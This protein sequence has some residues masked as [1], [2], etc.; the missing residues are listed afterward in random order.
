[1]N[2]SIWLSSSVFL[3]MAERR[4]WSDFLPEDHVS[5]QT[6]WS[7]SDMLSAWHPVALYEI[8]WELLLPVLAGLLPRG[9]VGGGV[10]MSIGGDSTANFISVEPLC[11][12]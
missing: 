3:K 12:G 6:V 8:Q 5:F 11:T 9:G 7:L 1:M 2:W 4:R 10:S